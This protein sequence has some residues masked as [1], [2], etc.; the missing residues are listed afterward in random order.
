[1]KEVGKFKG[2]ITVYNEADREEFDDEREDC[3]EKLVDILN[4]LHVKKKGRK[5][6]MD[7]AALQTS[8]ERYKLK[9]DLVDMFDSTTVDSDDI[10]EFLLDTSYEESLQKQ[11]QTTTEC[12]VRLYLLDGINFASRDI[13]SDSDPYM[14]V[15]CGKSKFD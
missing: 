5:M 6:C 10:M 9:R 1:M 13:G 7:P 12:V 2:H 14:I 15:S 8:E 4:Q 11:L 3:I